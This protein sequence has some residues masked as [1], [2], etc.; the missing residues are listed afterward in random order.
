MTQTE[1]SGG[2][3]SRCQSLSSLI[4]IPRAGSVVVGL[5]LLRMRKICPL[6]SSTIKLPLFI[7]ALEL[8]CICEKFVAKAVCR[9]FGF[10][11]IN[12]LTKSQDPIKTLRLKTKKP[13]PAKHCRL[14]MVL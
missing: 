8:Y 7:I 9:P 11:F 4:L 5:Y 10:Y 6:L 1:K 13:A 12:L 14:S 3:V 2:S